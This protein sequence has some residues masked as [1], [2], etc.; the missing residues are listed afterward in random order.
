[1][2]IEPKSVLTMFLQMFG[3]M[4]L[5]A[6]ALWFF[7]PETIV[8]TTGCPL[9]LPLFR[10]IGGCKVGAYIHYPT[11]TNG[12][13][14]FC[15]GLYHKILEMIDLVLSQKSTYNNSGRIANMRFLTLVKVFYYRV[16]T[17]L[18]KFC[19]AS[20]NFIMSNGRLSYF[21]SL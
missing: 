19:G 3:G 5:G 7:V 12:K 1:M 4:L 13:N 8:D 20:A 16:L 10:Y 18:Y 21:K 11:I 15:Y 17:E 9:V 6:E 2:L 14:F